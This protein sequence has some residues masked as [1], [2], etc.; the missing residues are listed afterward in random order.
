MMFAYASTFNKSLCSWGSKMTN[1][2]LLTS[3]FLGSSCP[4]PEID[5]RFSYSPPG[6]FCYDCCCRPTIPSAIEDPV[7]VPLVPAAAGN[8]FSNLIVGWSAR[9]RYRYGGSGGGTY[10]TLFDPTTKASTLRKVDGTL[11]RAWI[12]C[13]PHHFLTCRCFVSLACVPSIIR[14]GTSIYAV[15]AV[16]PILIPAQPVLRAS[17]CFE[18]STICF[19][20]GRR[21]YPTAGLWSAEDKLTF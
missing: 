7:E 11:T 19:A 14:N 1:T 21:F 18:R 16:S 15:G 4:L 12:W 8:M 5:V 3:M 20:P 6:P 10:T 13:R 9:S 17:T 2:T